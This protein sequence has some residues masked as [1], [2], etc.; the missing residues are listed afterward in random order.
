MRISKILILSIYICLLSA[1][2][3]TASSGKASI[4][5]INNGGVKFSPI[6][7]ARTIELLDFITSYGELDP[8]TQKNISLEIQEAIANNKEDSHL[9]IQQGAIFSL[10][11]SVL[12]DPEAAQK[13]L[14][15]LLKSSDLSA[16]D[17]SL[18]KLLLTMVQDQQKQLAKMREEAKKLEQLKQKNKALEQKLNDLKNIEKTM[19]ER[20]V[21]TNSN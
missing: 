7:H 17:A 21:K 10:P 4:D 8:E 18:V 20:N 6:A 2:V 3:S 5:S 15:A 11:N 1:C 12:K 13:M 9:Q 19:I 14:S 16:S